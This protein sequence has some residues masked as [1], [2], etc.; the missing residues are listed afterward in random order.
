M[1]KLGDGRRLASLDAA[2]DARL[3]E[4]VAGTDTTQAVLGEEE[5][6]AGGVAGWEVEGVV[7][8]V[9]EVVVG[10]EVGSRWIRHNDHLDWGQKHLDHPWCMEA[11]AQW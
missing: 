5:W 11:V 8:M 9:V 3:L 2:V 6:E 4:S 1:L 10:G 7:W